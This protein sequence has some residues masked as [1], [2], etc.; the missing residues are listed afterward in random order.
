MH[1]YSSV[2]CRPSGQCAAVAGCCKLHAGRSTM[3][4]V[5]GGGLLG[6]G[7]GNKLHAVLMQLVSQWTAMQIQYWVASTPFCVAKCDAIPLSIITGLTSYRHALLK[8]QLS[9]AQ[10]TLSVIKIIQMEL[11]E[12][13]TI[14]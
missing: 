10:L 12:Y 9:M 2:Q 8:P 14:K 6:A 1:C 7:D 13:N 4:W 11:I 5:E 3:Q